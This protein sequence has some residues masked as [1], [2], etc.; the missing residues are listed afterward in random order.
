MDLNKVAN[1]C[2]SIVLPVYNGEK[3]VENAI[4]SVLQQSYRNYELIV[5]DDGSTD[6]T[7]EIISKF[8]NQEKIRIIKKDNGGVS[9]ARNAGINRVT[10]DYL[11]FLDSDDKLMDNCL[12]TLVHYIDAY[13][14]VDLIVFSWKEQ[15]VVNKIRR[16]TDKKNFVNA[17]VC[18]E[19]IIKTDYECGGG[20][21]WNKLWKVK[22]IKD[23]DII[24]RFNEELVLCEDKEWAVRLLLNC[25]TIL[26][27]PDILYSYHITEEE[28]LSKIDFNIVDKKNDKKIMSFMKASINMEQVILGLRP[29]S[30]IYQSASRQ[31]MQDIILVCFKAARNRNDVLLNQAVPYYKQYVEKRKKNISIKYWIMLCY[32]R[33]KIFVTG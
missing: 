21:P 20:Y 4:Q 12:D 32:V 7:N 26:L 27:I 13:K 8:K 11:M 23:Q 9:S 19:Q 24:P 3:S 29:Q 18:I 10:G 31:S 1:V 14:D 25:K 30:R 22:A 2:I 17:D 15:G 6:K 33:M 16:V 5:V 28:H